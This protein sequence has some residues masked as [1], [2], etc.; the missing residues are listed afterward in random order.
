M[1][2]GW[3]CFH[4]VSKVAPVTG[5]KESLQVATGSLFGFSAPNCTSDGSWMEVVA[6]FQ[7]SPQYL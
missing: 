3:F 1:V 2:F 7:T 6:G 4:M 5:S